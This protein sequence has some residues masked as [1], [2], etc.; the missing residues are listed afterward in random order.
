M[1]CDPS[2]V[3]FPI[4]PPPTAGSLGSFV[5]PVPNISPFPAGFPEDLLDLLG[6]LQLLIPPGPIKPALNL[7][8]GKDVF[9]AIMKLLDQFFPF[10][11]M[12]KFFLP[13]LD[14]IICIIEVLC[15]LMNPFK[16]ISALN[17]L[18]T[19]CIPEFLNLFPQFAL[20]IMIISL[21]LL[22]L[23]LIEYLI[24]Q[25]LLFIEAIIRNINALVKAFQTS[26]ANGVL[27]IAQKL[28][29]VLCT[30]QNLFV[31]L[32]VFDIIIQVIKDI[33]KLL[34]SIP[35]CESGGNGSTNGCCSPDVCPTIVQSPYTNTA[36]TLQYLN[37]VSIPTATINPFVP[38]SFFGV[39][40]RTETWQLFDVNQTIAQA[41]SNIIDGYD[42]SPTIV[43]TPIFFPT[44]AVYTATT[45]PQQ[46][47][48]TIN[49]R[50]LYNP[51]N[52]GRTGTARYVQFNNCIVLA[53]TTRNLEIYNNTTVPINTGVLYIAGGLGYEDD[54]T[55]I[56]TGF[57]PDGVTPISAQATL[58]NFL[59]IPTEVSATPV[60]LPTDGYVFQ[61]M[62]YTFT[63][64]LPVLLQKNLVTLG[65]EPT[66]AFNRAFVNNVSF[67]DIAIKTLDLTNLVNGK[68]GFTFPDPAAAQACLAAAVAALRSNLTLAGVAEFQATT[69]LCLSKLQNDTNSA[70][71]STIGVG[72]SACQSNFTLNP[73]I[74]FTSQPI[75]VTVNLNENTGLPLTTNLPATVASSI[76][77]QITSY[78]T[79]GKVTN[80]SYDGYQTFTADI[81]SPEPGLGNIMVA[82]NQNILCTNTLP[83]DGTPPSHTLQDLQYQF[84]YTPFSAIPGSG[85]Q[86]RRDD[87]DAA[88]EGGKGGD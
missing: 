59:H 35:P 75:T 7:N 60:L 47:A 69:N 80:Y 21:L 37:A 65:C 78:I 36:G 33:L 1:P 79:F 50:L 46:A 2:A 3:S 20:I 62:Q 84:I 28:G 9:D 18:F 52:W 16:L 72:F 86:P 54:G 25:I 76:A 51:I 8:F 19:Q 61:T 4:P 77:D 24:A 38:G 49:L 5:L 88:R 22:L 39:D 70:L 44:D 73:V 23:A 40:V 11:M 85:E 30:F 68:A 56:L 64:N 74:Q 58:N 14:L 34:F 55:T 53:A 13:V 31:L 48:Y 15:A 10:L 57:A 41:F 17:R 42:V 83:S 32:S 45:A 66:V 82:Y 87:G 6:K 12:Y 81:T 29:T 43:P 63:P 67:G 26:N 71:G 27:A